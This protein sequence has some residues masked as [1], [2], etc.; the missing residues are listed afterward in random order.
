MINNFLLPS[1]RRRRRL[2]RTWFKQNSAT[3]YCSKETL[4]VLK[5]AFGSRL[6][7]RGTDFVW[8]P[9]SPDITAPDFFLWG[10][11][12]SRVYETRPRDLEDLKTRISQEIARIQRPMLENVFQN[13]LRRLNQCVERKGQHLSDI[14]YHK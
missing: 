9:R 10:Y 13:F 11:L 12:K 6:L 7:S 8:P 4:A 5:K 14:V 3:C 2:N 1:L